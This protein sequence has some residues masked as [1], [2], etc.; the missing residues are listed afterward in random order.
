MILYTCRSKILRI[1]GKTTIPSLTGIRVPKQ[2]KPMNLFLIFSTEH[3]KTQ[4]SLLPLLQFLRHA[5]R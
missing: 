5:E 4:F 3:S 2:I 1:D